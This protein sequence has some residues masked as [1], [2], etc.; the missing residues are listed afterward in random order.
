MMEILLTLLFAA[1]GVSG[2]LG[3]GYGALVFAIPLEPVPGDTPFG[4]DWKYAVKAATAS[5]ALFAIL[6]WLILRVGGLACLQ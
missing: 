2:M 6:L 5:L 4:R 3:F 1:S